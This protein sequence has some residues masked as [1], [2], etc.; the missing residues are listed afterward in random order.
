MLACYGIALR[1]FFVRREP[2]GNAPAVIA[3]VWFGHDGKPNA[4][5][6]SESL[7]FVLHQFLFRHR[8][9]KRR[10]YLV[11]FFLVTG[12][13]HRDVRGTAGDSR[14]DALLILAVAEL[15]ERLIIEAQ[16]GDVVP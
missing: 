13:L 15:H 4:L 3:V 16:P 10:Q 5:R 14:L 9:P 2:N 12:E 6:G 11:G 7:P 1:Y 8:K